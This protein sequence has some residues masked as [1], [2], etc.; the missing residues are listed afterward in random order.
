MDSGVNDTAVSRISSVK[1]SD[2]IAILE[3]LIC[4]LK[5]LKIP[6]FAQKRLVLIKV[7]VS[8]MVS[9]TTLYQYDT[10]VHIGLIFERLWLPVKG[11]SIKKTYF[12]YHFKC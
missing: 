5:L 8:T 4:N 1:V 3:N 2:G 6:I 11:I 9:L 7:Q 12:A 10:A